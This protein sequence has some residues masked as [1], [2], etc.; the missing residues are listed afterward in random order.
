M[1][2]DYL[3]DDNRFFQFLLAM[4]DN[5]LMG[6]IKSDPEGRLCWSMPKT[7]E[8]YYFGG[9]FYIASAP[10]QVTRFPPPKLHGVEQQPQDYWEI[11]RQKQWGRL[12]PKI[13][14]S[15]TWPGPGET[16]KAE[17]LAYAC[18]NLEVME[19]K[20]MGVFG[21]SASAGAL[22]RSNSLAGKRDAA[23]NPAKLMH[24]IALDNFCLLIYRVSEVVHYEYGIFPPRRTIYTYSAKENAWVDQP[25]NP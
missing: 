17:K 23:E 16:P 1:F 13:R 24:D 22:S 25:A 19:D 2:Q 10:I 21:G 7:K 11:E 3:E 18:L 20:P 8:I 4:N 12:T 15:F 6:D 9:K 14:A 5:I